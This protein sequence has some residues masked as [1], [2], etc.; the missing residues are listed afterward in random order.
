MATKWLDELEALH[1]KATPG[2]D[3]DHT[4][5]SPMAVDVTYRIAAIEALPRLLAIARAAEKLIDDSGVGCG[6]CQSRMFGRNWDA[7]DAALA[8]PEEKP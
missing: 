1:A 4:D 5:A 8:D 2:L 6:C 7:L 3:G